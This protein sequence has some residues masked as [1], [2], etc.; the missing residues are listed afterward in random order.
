LY[1]EFMEFHRTI[2]SMAER[3]GLSAFTLRYYERI[4]L[5]R[6]VQ[7]TAT[8]H[9]RYSADDERWIVFVTRLRATGM[10]VRKMLKYAELRAR[11]D[12]TAPARRRLLEEHRAFVADRI[13]VLRQCHALL[14]KKI[15]RYRKLE[16][17][18]QPSRPSPRR[19][20][21]GSPVSCA[22]AQTKGTEQ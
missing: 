9:R 17:S 3:Y 11:G 16:R 22:H 21:S 8:G 14:S 10:P 6:P 5:I 19:R 7:R 15:A 20:R 18:L 2:H 4:G 1:R 12:S 13:E